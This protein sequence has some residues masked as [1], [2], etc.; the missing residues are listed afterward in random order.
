MSANLKIEHGLFGHGFFSCC[1]IRLRSI[2]NYYNQ[3]HIM[4]I[5]DSS[6]QWHV[7]KD[8]PNED[9]TSK[10]FSN[11]NHDFATNQALCL[12]ND[13]SLDQKD[14]GVWLQYE[15]YSDINYQHS[16]ILINKYF[17]PSTEVLSIR[18]SLYRKYRIN[19]RQTIGICYRGTDKR[20]ETTVPSYESILETILLL[21]DKNPNHT[22]LVQ[23][24]EQEFLSFLNNNQISFVK[25]DETHQIPSNSY[26][27]HHYLTPG[28]K[29][30][31]AQNFLATILILSDCSHLITNSGNVGLWLCLYRNNCKN[32]V[33]FL[34]N[35]WIH[36]QC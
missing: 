34:N 11:N 28:S 1:T 24:D 36:H 14:M 22:L 9:I 26:A 7:Y 33:Q 19:P 31:Y 23:T 18:H 6:I 10:L 27:V 17:A 2:V 13:Y 35:E 20:T 16:Q 5:V 25:F 4:P 12:F 29:T 30:I 21:K 32:V 15:K 8:N 3:H